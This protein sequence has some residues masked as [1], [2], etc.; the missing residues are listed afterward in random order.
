MGLVNS[1]QMAEKAKLVYEGGS[2]LL[3]EAIPTTAQRILDVGCG[4]GAVGE[5][6]KQRQAAEVVGLTYS[7]AEAELAEKVLDRVEICD[8]NQFDLNGL[9]TFDC[10][11]CSHVLEHLYWPEQ[12]LERIRPVL[13]PSG[14]L[15]VCLPNVLAWRQRVNFLIGRFRYTEGGLMDRT[16]FRFFDWHTAQSLVADAGYRLISVKGDG[17][18]PCAKFLFKLGALLSR[19][20]VRLVPG[21]FSWQFVIVGEPL[22]TSN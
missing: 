10:V 16:H 20:A 1:I 8:L 4:N 2:P 14:R 21:L 12:L 7:L 3:F 18:F 11:I 6:V 5:V 22:Q 19:A 15:I 17:V 13:T 9:G